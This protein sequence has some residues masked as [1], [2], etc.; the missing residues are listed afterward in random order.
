MRNAAKPFLLVVLAAVAAGCGGTADESARD[1]DNEENRAEI[2]GSIVEVDTLPPDESI[3]TPTE[4]LAN[5]AIDAPQTNA[6]Y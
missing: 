5:G 4:D 2:N 1:L 6:S 3:A